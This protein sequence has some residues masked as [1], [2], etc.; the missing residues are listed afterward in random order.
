MPAV[1][2][3]A[4]CRTR[5]SL[6]GRVVQMEEN[7]LKLGNVVPATPQPPASTLRL[8]EPKAGGVKRGPHGWVP[9]DPPLPAGRARG[10]RCSGAPLAVHRVAGWGQGGVSTVLGFILTRD[11]NWLE[12]S[13]TGSAG[14]PPGTR[15]R[16]DCW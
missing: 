10:H 7:L 9:T 5:R 1:P 14:S 16:G 15:L 8:E 11:P 13:T 3:P 6:S 2:R 12:A 4:D